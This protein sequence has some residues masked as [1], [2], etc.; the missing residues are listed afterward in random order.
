MREKIVCFFIIIILISDCSSLAMAVALLARRVAQVCHVDVAQILRASAAADAT[1]AERGAGDGDDVDTNG[2][3]NSNGSAA[4]LLGD[5]ASAAVAFDALISAA[6]LRVARV[7]IVLDDL[8][9]LAGIFLKN[10]MFFF[11]NVLKILVFGFV[12]NIY[13]Y[14]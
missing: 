1:D 14:I 12:F 5:E 7:V 4:R 2:N 9:M 3:T 6:A 13:I 8:D 10:E 11:V